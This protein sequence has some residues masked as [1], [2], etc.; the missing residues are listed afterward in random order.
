MQY[1]CLQLRVQAQ[2]DSERTGQEGNLVKWAR[3]LDFYYSGSF[4]VPMV[5]DAITP[6]E[7][8]V[9]KVLVDTVSDEGTKLVIEGTVES[10]CTGSGDAVTG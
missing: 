4:S 9:W 3:Y 10:A 2:R 7:L 6:S 8:K 5:G 1:A